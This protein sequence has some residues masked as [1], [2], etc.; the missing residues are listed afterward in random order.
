[1][2]ASRRR[3]TRPRFHRLFGGGKGSVCDLSSFATGE[4][5]RREKAAKDLEIVGGSQRKGDCCANSQFVERRGGEGEK[6]SAPLWRVSPA[7]V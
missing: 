6:K 3:D 7:F 4:K 5:K 1:L 2:T